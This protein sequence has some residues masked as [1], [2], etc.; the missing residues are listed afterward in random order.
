MEETLHHIIIMA[1]SRGIQ[2]YYG[3]T[4]KVLT[5]RLTKNHYSV[6]KKIP[7]EII[8]MTNG[9]IISDEVNVM[10]NEL[11]DKVAYE[12]PNKKKNLEK[13]EIATYRKVAI[14]AAK[15]LGYIEAL[16][17]LYKADSVA[18]IQRIMV[19]ERHKISDEAKTS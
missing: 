7:L 11:E 8:E 6:S 1:T 15:D 19:T 13:T 5:L 18:E 14:K 3:R 2:L 12:T 10:I 17:L 4:K 9:D 16:P